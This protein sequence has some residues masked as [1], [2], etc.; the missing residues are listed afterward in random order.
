MTLELRIIRDPCR[1]Q[2]KHRFRLF[3]PE[4]G[5]IG[6]SPEC[7]WVLPDPDRYVSASHCSVECVDGQ[8][9]LMDTSR[10]GVF[11][12]GSR[13]PVGYERTVALS[14]GDRVRIGQYEFAVKVHERKQQQAHVGGSGANGADHSAPVSVDMTGLSDTVAILPDTAHLSG[15]HDR[16]ERQAVGHLVEEGRAAVEQPDEPQ[17]PNSAYPSAVPAGESAIKRIQQPGPERGDDPMHSDR[18]SRPVD[19]ASATS[20]AL[21][22]TF[23]PTTI[24]PIAMERHC[25]LLGMSDQVALR[26]YKIL[27]TR[28]R[29]RLSANQWRSV[30]ITSEGQGVGKTVTAINLAVAFAQDARSPV[31]LVDLDLHRPS[32]G[33]YLGMRSTKGVSDYLLGDATIEEI[34]YSPGVQGLAIVPGRGPLENASELLA[35]ARMAELVGYLE[36]LTP[37]HV[38]LYDLPPLLM[39]DDVLVFSPQ[40]DCA[41]NVVAVGVTPRAALERSKEVLSELNIIGTVVNRV[42]EYDQVGHQYYY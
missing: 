20:D 4:G 36:A 2:V 10:N 31:I 42:A 39:S 26:G 19:F 8:Y 18:T 7:S 27:R 33:K 40:M 41:L 13:E 3:G 16:A 29:R 6:R 25:V 11:I 30:G 5:S 34:I 37:R 17:A 35:S 28:L 38:I 22:R 23:I 24:D 9:W 12:N 32:V 21:P 15:L 1:D 14:S